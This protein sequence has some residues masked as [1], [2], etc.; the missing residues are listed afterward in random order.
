MNVVVLT[1]DKIGSSK[2][3]TALASL[4]GFK[5][6]TI[7][8]TYT[9]WSKTPN[10]FPFALKTIDSVSRERINALFNEEDL[11]VI[12]A[13]R[14]LA[15]ISNYI[16]KKNPKV[17][18]IQILKP[19]L[20]ITNFDVVALP[21]H[22][23][24]NPD[25]VYDNLVVF[26]GAITRTPKL[27]KLENDDW[28]QRL[29]LLPKKRFVLLIGGET[30]QSVF[31]EHH[32]RFLV[33]KAL[34]LASDNN[35]ALLV[36][37]S[38]R[39]GHRLTHIIFQSIKRSKVPY[40]LHDVMDGGVNPYKAFLHFGDVFITTGDSISMVAECIATD[41]PVLIYA[42][43]G[44]L[45]HKH[46]KYIKWLFRKEYAYPL[47]SKLPEVG[48]AKNTIDKLFKDQVLEKLGK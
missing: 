40:I 38:R 19:D 42:S 45:A 30:K 46:H 6:K 29:L 14:R 26:D 27:T 8:I 16:K 15:R 41:K 12:A 13:G 36:S 28:K 39:T 23:I 25:L 20:P 31:M 35:G 37:N 47:Q 43:E 3:A 11:L 4:L 18:N 7:K 9:P 22:D 33:K 32:A 1:D 24:K 10:F 34:K 5:Y 44:M 21:R 17:K 48:H 2:Q